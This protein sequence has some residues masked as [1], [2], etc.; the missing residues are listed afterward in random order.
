MAR[1]HVWLATQLSW[2]SVLLLVS[3][4]LHRA[5]AE[6]P[7]NSLHNTPSNVLLQLQHSGGMTVRQHSQTDTSPTSDAAKVGTQPSLQNT[8][9]P[10][11]HQWFAN[12]DAWKNKFNDRAEAWRQN[13][14]ALNAPAHDAIEK[15]SDYTK[16]PLEMYQHMDK[17]FG[18]KVN[19]LRSA[20]QEE[21]TKDNKEI[22]DLLEPAMTLAAKSADV[23]PK[24][25]DSFPQLSRTHDNGFNN[26]K[27]PPSQ[28]EFEQLRKDKETAQTENERLQQELAKLKA[29]PS[30]PG[31]EPAAAGD[32]GQEEPPAS[33][34]SPASAAN[35]HAGAAE[36]EA[37]QHPASEESDAEHPTASEKAS[38]SRAEEDDDSD[39]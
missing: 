12:V 31:G 26:W 24:L 20:A 38:G 1:C 15:S 27:L 35:E 32:D 14:N 2:A 33:E 17:I 4:W 34:S 36:E 25:T 39:D 13:V 16:R 11:P 22:A 21:Y 18:T 7:D 6:R 37:S 3:S 9:G 29:G 5:F 30:P 19:G 8:S 23:A 10:A 28:E